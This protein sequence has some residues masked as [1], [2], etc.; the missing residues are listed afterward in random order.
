MESIV[1][2]V[3]LPCSY[4]KFG[5]LQL[6]TLA[7]RKQ[8]ETLCDLQ[9][10]QCPFKSC[11]WRGRAFGPEVM[12][13][14][15]EQHQVD[16]PESSVTLQGPLAP[17]TFFKS[18]GVLQHQNRL[19]FVHVLVSNGTIDCVVK[20]YGL[21]NE[22]GKYSASLSLECN[23]RIVAAIT[24]INSSLNVENMYAADHAVQFQID[25]CFFGAG[26]QYF[27]LTISIVT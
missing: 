7:E 17:A 4:W 18:S 8:H 14:I 13:H 21:E 25:R 23:R 1:E 12:Q 6:V 9:P 26:A 27:T 11:I 22:G 19:F 3:P 24:S 2:V 5:C 10:K 20:L 16:V 15:K